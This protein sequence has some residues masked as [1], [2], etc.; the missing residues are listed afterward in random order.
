MIHVNILTLFEYPSFIHQLDNKRFGKNYAFFENSNK[1][2]IWDLLVV[3]EGIK[4]NK[5]VK[6]KDGGL[7]FISGEPSESR[8]Y[9]QGFINQFDYIISSH[10]KLK[11]PNSILSQQALNWHYGYNQEEKNYKYSFEQLSKFRKPTKI[12]NISII[13]S[14]KKM[15]PGHLKRVRFIEK[16][17][18]RFPNNID[19]FGK[20]I[21]PI[22][23]KADAINPYRFH[24]CIENSFIPDYWSEKLAD[25]ILGYSV[26]LYCGC[27]NITDYFNQ[28][29]YYKL[30]I[31]DVESAIE[32]ISK[33]LN[34]PSKYYNAM[35]Y[36]LEKTRNL[37]LN[38]YNI[39]SVLAEHYGKYGIIN[40]SYSEKII[41]PVNH[42]KTYPFLMYFLRAR[43]LSYKVLDYLFL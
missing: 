6:V 8:V 12:K 16:L 36:N 15:M 19:C 38:K 33:L 29:F 11:H 14:S 27:S 35:I 40:N 28:T 22:N 43:R 17:M 32:L 23:D 34:N 37:I 20:G 2:I 24:I 25:P 10:R 5:K 42:F 21:N 31:S 18:K 9:P 13:S 41:M 26:P 3:Y 7:L 4:I 1:D 30:D 39:F